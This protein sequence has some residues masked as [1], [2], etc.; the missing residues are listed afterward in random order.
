MAPTHGNSLKRQ[1]SQRQPPTHTDQQADVCSIRAYRLCNDI[2]RHK[3]VGKLNLEL[4]GVC[5]VPQSCPTLC[6]PVDCNLPG[7]LSMGSSR[8]EYWSGF[9]RGSSQPRDRTHVS[10]ISCTGRWILYHWC[11][12]GSP[13]L[14]RWPPK[15]Q[16]NFRAIFQN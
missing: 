16:I 8:Q 2:T 11:H 15:F 7:C 14:L 1:T 9:S 6:H 5:H 10:C 12:L 13:R 3:G 4:A